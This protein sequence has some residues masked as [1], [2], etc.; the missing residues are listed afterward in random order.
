MKILVVGD[1]HSSIHEV[2]ATKAFRKLGHQS[3]LF[4]WHT[5]FKSKNLFLDIYYRAQN[6][7]IFGP[8]INDL[9]KDLIKKIIKFKPDLIFVYRGTH[10]KPKT[11]SKIKFILPSCKVFG[12]N[13]DDPFSSGHPYWLWRLFM[14]CIPL[15]DLMF[16]Y[17]HHNLKDFMKKKANSVALLRSWFIPELNFKIKLSKKEKLKYECDVVF[18]GHYENDGR[19]ECLEEI[20]KKGHNLRIFGPPNEWNKIL[21]QSKILKHLEPVHQVWNLEYNK[22]IS[23]AKIALCF[24]SKLNRDTYTRRCFEIPASGTMLLS[25]YS[26][27]LTTIFNKGKEI[28]LFKSKNQLIKKINFYLQNDEIRKK[29]AKNGYLKVNKDGHDIVSRMSL[30]IDYYNNQITRKKFTN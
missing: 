30:V 28:D 8:K 24:F 27:D 10:V 19:L 13:N 9:N 16:V 20:V 18:V 15:Y 7:F 11:I 17:R 14:K 1:G 2:A 6:K 26:K 25:E 3:K 5:Y 29:I 12:Y 22:I 23:G 4:C 21:R